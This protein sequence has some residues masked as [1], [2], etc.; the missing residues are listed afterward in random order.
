MYRR[1]TALSVTS[2]KSNIRNELIIDY[3]TK[4]TIFELFEVINSSEVRKI[5][6]KHKCNRYAKKLKAHQLI[7]LLIL[8]QQNQCTGTRTVQTSFEFNRKLRRYLKLDSIS[9]T[10]V[11]RRLQSFPIAAIEE[12][13]NV[14]VKR[15]GSKYRQKISKSLHGLNLIDASTITKSLKGMEW[16]KFR[17]S[18]AGI[19]L[20]LSLMYHDEIA[21]PNNVFVSKAKE[22]DVAYL[23]DLVVVSK[24]TI[25]VF[26]RGYV[27]YQAFDQF[28]DVGVLFVTRLREN[29][30]TWVIQRYEVDEK[31]KVVYHD[32]VTVGCGAKKTKNAFRYIQLRDDDGNQVHFITNVMDKTPEEIG[33]IY[34]LRWQIELFFKWIKQN[35]KIKHFYATSEQAVTVQIFIALIAYC[36][37]HL[38]SAKVD[39]RVS[40]RK[41]KSAALSALFDPFRDVVEQMMRISP[42]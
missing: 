33:D 5:F 28:S 1:C 8:A 18:K 37:F 39:P 7:V 32:L 20:H 2:Y 31:S 3:T 9:H 21:Y 27:D 24:D 11:F 26:D 41:I 23:K 22:H 15:L 42:H 4:T 19:K 13:F 40:L 12:V 35:L 14:V 16:A 17:K 30:A 36:L 38:I 6:K 25:N 34:K 29:A 10:Q